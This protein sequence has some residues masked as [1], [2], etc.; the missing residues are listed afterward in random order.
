MKF[1]WQRADSVSENLE[2]VARIAASVLADNSMLQFQDSCIG[3]PEGIRP[4]IVKV[5][6]LYGHNVRASTMSGLVTLYGDDVDYSANSVVVLRF[7]VQ[8]GISS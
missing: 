4:L 5:S 1:P 2:Y 3:G 8:G 7:G 6:K